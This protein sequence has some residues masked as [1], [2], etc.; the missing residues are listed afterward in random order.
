M[1]LAERI[2][3]VDDQEVTDSKPAN[4]WNG[5]NP[6]HCAPGLVVFAPTEA[7]ILTGITVFTAAGTNTV[8]VPLNWSEVLGVDATVR[9]VLG[10]AT[11]SAGPIGV[12]VVT[13]SFI[14]P[15]ATFKV[16]PPATMDV[17]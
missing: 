14:D 11:K 6:V 7:L 17:G 12:V 16:G 3:G 13:L 9:S 2:P 5:E 8:K 1:V 10:L 15:A 4:S